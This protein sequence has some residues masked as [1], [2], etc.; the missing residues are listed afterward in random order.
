MH[1]AQGVGARIVYVV[2]NLALAVVVTSGLSELR[3]DRYIAFSH[4]LFADD[5]EPSAATGVRGL[6]G[7]V[8]KR[9]AR[10]RHSPDGQH[11]AFPARCAR[12]VPMRAPQTEAP[13]A[14]LRR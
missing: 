6:S 4:A 11:S 8:L 10:A 14:L 9:P 13:V 1:S 5:V 12:S 2:L 3:D 7:L